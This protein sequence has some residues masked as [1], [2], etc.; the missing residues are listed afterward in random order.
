MNVDIWRQ[1]RPV[2]SDLGNLRPLFLQQLVDERPDPVV[3]D[4]QVRE[5][6]LV[7]VPLAAP[8]DHDAGAEAGGANLLTHIAKLRRSQVSS[9]Y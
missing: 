1:S 8:A 5:I 7:G 3:F 2:D 9:S 6:V 4:Q